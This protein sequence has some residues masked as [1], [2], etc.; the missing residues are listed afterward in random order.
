MSD[1]ALNRDATGSITS[2]LTFFALGFMGSL[3]FWLLSPLL[4]AESAIAAT[5]LFFVGG[6][7]PSIA[8]LAVVA[9]H[10]GCAGLRRWLTQCGQW[11]VGWRWPSSSLSPSRGPWGLCVALKP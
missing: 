11:R 2:T 5:G 9:R 7:G 4:K 10:G 3:A 8:A 1:P 6:F